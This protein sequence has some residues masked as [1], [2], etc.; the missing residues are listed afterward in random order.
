MF[1]HLIKLNLKLFFEPR[2]LDVELALS[3]RDR[4][5]VLNFDGDCELLA[6][7]RLPF[8]TDLNVRVT[9]SKVI[10]GE[11]VE[12]LVHNGCEAGDVEGGLVSES[13]YYNVI[14]S[15]RVIYFEMHIALISIFL[16]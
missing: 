8:D 9:N 3:E 5:R 11:E 15:K 2:T 14:Q 12:V 16:T 6:G 13:I 1:P 10:L 4:E 7:H